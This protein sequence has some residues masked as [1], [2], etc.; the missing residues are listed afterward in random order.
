MDV[1]DVLTNLEQLQPFFQPIFSADEHSV[2]GYEI[3]PRYVNDSGVIGLEAFLEDESIPEEYRMDIDTIILKSAL[4]K[5]S[6]AE[7]DFSIFIHVNP[8]LMMLDHGE[9]FLALIKEKLGEEHLS[10]VVIEFPDFKKAEDMMSFGHLLNYYRTYGIKIAVDH[11]DL[12]SNFDR[13]AS[14]SPHILKVNLDSLT[15]KEWDTHREVIHSLGELARKIGAVLMFESIETVYQLQFAWKSGGR[16]YQGIYLAEPAPSF[17]EKDVLKERFK[18]ECH[19][20][21]VSEKK[22]LEQKFQ[23]KEQLKES[24]EEA[25]NKW[26]PTS[27][28]LPQLISLAKQ[29]EG[30]SFRLYICDEDGFQVSPNI[31]K[32]NGQWLIQ[33]EYI[34]NNW[35]WRPYFLK[36]IIKMRNSQKGQ[37]S[38][39]YSD[40]ETGETI[41]TF[42][43]GLQEKEYLY[44]DISYDYLF[45]HDIF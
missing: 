15:Y 9:S 38:D 29:L 45:E 33:N 20:F 21:I 8:Q 26:K 11:V 2:V 25:V 19:S 27:T 6:T 35:S 44:V 42:S 18:K 16:Y 7:G 10:R 31:C 39:P 14:L 5:I 37:L 40:I 43:I 32:A 41:R 4:E 30:V 12:N 13:I 17:I 24:I 34:D 22:S 1:M 36:T 3:A 23:K 28:S